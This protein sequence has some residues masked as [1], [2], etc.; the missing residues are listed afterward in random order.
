MYAE[1]GRWED[2]EQIKAIM[3]KEGLKKTAGCSMFEKNSETHRFINQ[4]RS[5]SKTYLIYNV[6]DILLRKIGEDIYIHNVS[7]FSPAHLMKNRAKSPQHHSVRLAI[8]FG[9]ISTSVGNP[10][11]V[12]N[13]TRICEDCH[14]AVKK[15][16]EIT[17]RELIVR[18]PKC[19][20][21]FRNGCCS[22]GDYW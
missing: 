13:N 21:H 9:L 18:D 4:D 15:I 6:L 12:R 8:S 14:S 16:S 3:E 22:C 19:F 7:K 5:H 11:L 2:V 10:V 20:H 17:K 1:A